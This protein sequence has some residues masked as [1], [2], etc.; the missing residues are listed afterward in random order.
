MSATIAQ[1]VYKLNRT[2]PV[3]LDE[4]TT[5]EIR[6]QPANYNRELIQYVGEAEKAGDRP[7]AT[8][9]LLSG[10]L[11]GWNLGDDYSPE[12][13]DS[14]GYFSQHKMFLALTEDFK[15]INGSK[16]DSADGSS[17]QD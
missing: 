7:E 14:L 4:D 5:I 11:T 13:L 9:R 8:F 15:E 6:Y 2:I 12:A 10:L 3:A 16:K 1:I 17:S